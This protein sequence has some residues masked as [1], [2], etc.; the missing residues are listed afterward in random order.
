MLLPHPDNPGGGLRGLYQQRPRQRRPAGFFHRIWKAIK[1]IV[2]YRSKYG[3]WDEVLVGRAEAT[4]IVE[5]INDY[6]E[7][8]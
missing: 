6:L 4:R 5:F 2:G 8:N 3:E 1:Y 7:G